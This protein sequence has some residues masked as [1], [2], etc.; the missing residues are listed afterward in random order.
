MLNFT[1]TRR[2]VLKIAGA[3]VAAGTTA[4]ACSR[5]NRASTNEQGPRGGNQAGGGGAGSGRGRAL[6]VIELGGGNDGL[7]MLAPVGHGRYHDARPT[8]ALAG[9]EVEDWGDGWGLH[10]S[11][12][13]LQQFG[14]G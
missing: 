12:A 13:Q 11:L 1:P 7:S 8:V 2:E 3:G 6:V 4:A 9:K 5:L 10:K 14:L